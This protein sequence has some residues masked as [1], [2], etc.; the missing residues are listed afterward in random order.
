MKDAGFT[1]MD[2]AVVSSDNCSRASV[3]RP[4]SLTHFGK[5]LSHVKE[6]GL[7][8][9]V[10]MILG[11]PGDKIDNMIQTLLDLL[12]KPC[13][14][15]ASIYYP[16]PG[17]ALFSAHKEQI[18]FQD[19]PFWRSTVASF[20]NFKGERDQVMTLFYLARMVNFMKHLLARYAG[21]EKG[22]TLEGWITQWYEGLGLVQ[23]SEALTARRVEAAT[24]WSG[25]QLGILMVRRFVKGG[26]FEKVTVQKTKARSV[27]LF[28][29]ELG[30]E[31]L[32]RAFL[33]RARRVPLATVAG[34]AEQKNQ[35]YQAGLPGT[36]LARAEP[37]H[38]DG[39]SH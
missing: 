19:P 34:A 25:D 3:D 24:S 39:V 33:E 9:T 26:V 29:Q 5:I 12:G 23:E 14:I 7:R 31:G 27:Y 4:G 11:L 18:R 35:G 32:I 21:L 17:S 28:A 8:T 6:Q 36:P 20:E 15:G 16:V 37:N 30:D 10:H 2:L 38:D 13:L 22:R 1:H